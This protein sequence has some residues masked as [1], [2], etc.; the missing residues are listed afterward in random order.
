MSITENKKF[1]EKDERRKSERH[2]LVSGLL[3][4][5]LVNDESSKIPITILEISKGGLSF[6]VKKEKDC[7]ALNSV[8]KLEIHIKSHE[9]HLPCKVQIRSV[10]KLKDGNFRHGVQ[11]VDKS[12]NK[13]ALD[14]LAQF[15]LFA[16]VVLNEDVA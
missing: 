4:G 6:L 5:Y 14:F 12:T 10:E 13:E 11:V 16:D 1:W 7:A 8:I 3:T 9:A 2:I 15:I